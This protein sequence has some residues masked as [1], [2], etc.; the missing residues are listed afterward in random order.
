VSLSE[1]RTLGIATSE[2]ELNWPADAPAD[3]NAWPDY[4]ALRPDVQQYVERIPQ[5]RSYLFFT[6][7][8]PL[9]DPIL[10]GLLA[11]VD[12]AS[13][14][15]ICAW[16]IDW[17]RS[18]MMDYALLI[19]LSMLTSVSA[20][21]ALNRGDIELAKKR[22]LTTARLA[23]QVTQGVVRDSMWAQERCESRAIRSACRVAERLP[24]EERA[25]FLKEVMSLF[26]EEPNL[27]RPL[28]GE[29]LRCFARLDRNFKP[30]EAWIPGISSGNQAMKD[31]TTE[32]F[33]RYLSTITMDADG[34]RQAMKVFAEMDKA[35][36]KA[37]IFRN[38]L[39][40]DL[41]DIAGLVGSCAARRRMLQAAIARLEGKE[42]HPK[43][44]FLDQPMEQRGFAWKSVGP[45]GQFGERDSFEPGPQHGDDPFLILRT[46]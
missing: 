33:L 15:P 16:K 44:P 45:D 29:L 35:E 36:A 27:L 9:E 26:G 23:R 11:K 19:R 22:T 46:S 2:S 3:Q 6:G 31:A 38:V 4:V 20:V 13:L 21:N 8:Q 40:R 18:V 32:T 12:K 5:F 34:S 14:K 37:R 39:P 7:T 1:A 30:L 25:P 24:K 10:P 28:R 43:D 41:D 17:G 42:S